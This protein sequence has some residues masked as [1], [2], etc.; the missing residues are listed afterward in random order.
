MRKGKAQTSSSM[1]IIARSLTASDKR[2]TR[3]I[4]MKP[5]TVE[6]IVSKFVVNVPKLRGETGILALYLHVDRWGLPKVTQ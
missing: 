4:V 3:N 2:V 5:S 6:G 1:E